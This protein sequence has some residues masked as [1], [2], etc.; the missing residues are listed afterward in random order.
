MKKFENL[1][2]AVQN[3][4][5]V[6]VVTIVET[7][8]VEIGLRGQMMMLYSDG[9]VEGCLV[10]SSITKEVLNYIQHTNWEKPGV[11]KFDNLSGYQF[12]WDK[13]VNTRKAV[14][15]GGGH[16]SQPLVDILAMIDFEVTVVDDR[17][18]FANSARFAR[19]SKVIC[20]SFSH[21]LSEN[22]ISIDENTAVVIVTRGHRYDMEC[23]RQLIAIKT[24]YLGMIGSRH[25]VKGIVELLNGEGISR[26]CL[27][28]L[29]S[30]IG[31]DIGANTPTE[32]A[33]SIAVEI[34]A[35]F[36]ASSL[37]PLSLSQKGAAHE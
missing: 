33:L 13:W 1:F 4:E 31:I 8:P 12:F 36:N 32:I 22:E 7:P 19:A 11:I 37:Q 34:M 23:L 21:V 14:V 24:G 16:I 18:E 28:H 17:P 30:P 6:V 3:N 9:R 10:N 5:P 26:E 15:F 29:R 35:V 20:D 25:R 2:A 27:Q